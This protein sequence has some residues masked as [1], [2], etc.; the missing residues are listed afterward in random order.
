MLV[1]IK[2]CKDCGLTSDLTKWVTKRGKIEGL[3]CLAC[4]NIR[5]KAYYARPERTLQVAETNKQEKQKAS[6]K[7]AVN[8]HRA[9]DRGRLSTQE[10]NKANQARRRLEDPLYV[11]NDRLRAVVGTA[12]KRQGYSKT[13]RTHKILGASFEEVMQHLNCPNG[14]PE[15]YELDHILPMALAYDEASAIKLNHYTNL[16]LLSKA[17]NL[18]K[19]D[20]LPDGRN[21]RDLSVEEKKELIWARS[22][23]G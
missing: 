3:R 19:R 9:T 11:F 20:K 14:I 1:K 17:A 4:E 10:A 7:L 18:E 13:S 5:S 8:T 6:R 21:A 23:V 16:Q 2:T 15:G 22:S 12:L